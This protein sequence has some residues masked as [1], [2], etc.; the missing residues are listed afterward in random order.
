MCRL[1]LL[2]LVLFFTLQLGAQIVYNCNNDAPRILLAGD[3]WAQYMGDD[4]VHNDVLDQYGHDDKFLITQTLGSTPNPPYIGTA[5]AVSGSLA[6][7]W[8]NTTDYAY[9]QNMVAALQTNPSVDWVVLSIGGNDILA[10]RSEGGWYKDMDL[11]RAGSEDSL[12]TIIEQQTQTVIDAALAVRPNIKVLISSYEYP[13]F[14]VEFGTCW[15]YA[16]DKREDLSRDPVN[17]LITNA[18]L[19]QMMLTAESRRKQMADQQSRVFY[20]NGIGL[21]HYIYGSPTSPEGVLPPPQ[22]FSPYAPGGDPSQPTLRSNFRIWGDPIHLDAEGYS[23]KAK[24]QMDNQ[25]FPALR[26]PVDATF[27][28][29]GGNRD[30]WVNVNGNEFGASGIRMGDNGS[31][32]DWRGILSFNTSSLPDNA[33]VTGARIYLHRSG[34]GIGSNPYS[35]SDRAPHLDIKSGSFG[36]PVVEFSDGLAPADGVDVGCFH[37]SVDE[38]YYS[39]RIDIATAYLQHI[40][41]NGITQ[42]RIYFDLADFWPNYVYYFDGSQQGL[43]SDGEERLAPDELVYEEKIVQTTDAEGN[44]QEELRTVVAV[45]HNG[46]SRFMGTTAPFLDL[47]YELSLPVNL[48]NFQAVLQGQQVQLAWSSSQEENF[49]GYRLERSANGR[50]WE[51]L[52]F[53]PGTAAG[54]YE[55]MDSNPLNGDNYYRLVM[56]DLDGS[57]NYSPVE[58]VHFISTSAGVTVYPNPFTD[59]LQLSFQEATSAPLSIKLIDLL[60]RPL[61]SWSIDGTGVRQLLLSIPPDLPTGSYWLRIQSGAQL[62]WV[63]VIKGQK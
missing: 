35:L 54:R 2:S 53:I 14:D 58:L 61:T 40:N 8:A 62:N 45:A 26:G 39:T 37:G 16:C 63:R 36:S 23:Y 20:D 7:H 24:N 38:D 17:D 6:R 48:L 44:T 47:S 57:I 1:L 13:N 59:Q 21:M 22:P 33:Q 31:S 15:I 50:D 27:F 10:G 32:V 46:L 5:Y 25:F 9:I 41:T 11:D 3:S 55:D 28:S 34:E 19:N 43:D 29:E 52:S 51:E 4:G 30:G 42:F 56:E 49:R 12:L 18:E 60:G